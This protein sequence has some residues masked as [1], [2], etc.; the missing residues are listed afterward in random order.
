M[1]LTE[2]DCLWT[3]VSWLKQLLCH[4]LWLRPVPAGR[5]DA[6]GGG[7]AA[8][9]RRRRRRG[10]VACEARPSAAATPAA[11]AAAAAAAPSRA[12]ARRDNARQ[13]CR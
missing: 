11:A 6:A 10:A 2:P 5:F 7:C 4:Q 13:S 12:G 3:Q 9:C 8:G 1:H